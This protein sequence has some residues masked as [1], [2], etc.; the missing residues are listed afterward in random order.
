[1]RFLLLLL[2]PALALAQPER[3]E[4]GQRLKDFELAWEKHEDPALRKAALKDLPNVTQQF[5]SLQLGEAGRTLD[6]AR[7]RLTGTEPSEAQK[8]ITSL[9]AMPEKMLY[10]TKDKRITVTLKHF[11][12]MKSEMPAGAKVRL[13]FPGEEK[14]EKEIGKLPMEVTVPLPR[15][16]QPLGAATGDFFLQVEFIAKDAEFR[17]DVMV[18]VIE[19]ADN[20]YFSSAPAS[21]FESTQVYDLT[22]KDYSERIKSLSEGEIPETNVP[23]NRLL[24]TLTK[25]Q[26]P[27]SLSNMTGQLYLTFH[28]GKTKSIA[29]RLYISDKGSTRPREKRPVVIAL[30]GAGG[31]ENLFFEGYGAGHIVKECEKRGWYLVAPR[32]GISFTGTPP[33]KEILDSL[34]KLFPIDRDEVFVVG[35]SMGAGQAIALAQANPA[36]YRGVAALGGGGRVTDAKALGKL[37][38]FIGIGEKDFALKGA[39]DL[40][41]S[42]E[43]A[44]YKEYPDLEHLIIVREALPDVFKQWDEILEKRKNR[45]IN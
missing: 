19:P 9:Y 11:Y 29:T 35:H 22:R 12:K 17:R 15:K 43:S 42:L 36:W 40:K 45:V 21:P 28:Y 33:V 6:V 39:K 16:G 30:H 10:T 25:M 20:N 18:S 38:V 1:M 32:S 13:G 14:I 27:T 7:W 44:T 5:F 23:V 37:P 3:Y 41:K 2:S 8:W 26:M 4:L 34:E 24:Q 31:S